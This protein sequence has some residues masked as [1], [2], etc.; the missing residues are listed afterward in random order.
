[1]Q[2]VVDVHE[3]DDKLLSNELLGDGLDAMDQTGGNDASAFVA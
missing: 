3:M 2:Y 1:M